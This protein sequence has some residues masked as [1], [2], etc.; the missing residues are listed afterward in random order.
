ML[1]LTPEFCKTAPSAQTMID[2]LKGTWVSSL[3]ADMNVVA[4][5]APHFEEDLRVDWVHSTLSGG[6]TGKSI[7]E[8]GPLEAYH[9]YK[10]EKFGALPAVSIESNNIAFL[11]CLIIKELFHLRSS[12]LYGDFIPY[13]SANTNR[14][15]ICWASGILY[16][17]VRPLE[18]L[19]HMQRTSDVIFLWTH[20][21][22]RTILEQ[23]SQAHSFFDPRRNVFIEQDGFICEHHYRSYV[24]EKGGVFSGG[25]D[26]FS[27]WLTKQDIMAFLAR[28]GFTEITVGLDHPQNPAGPA[29]YFLACRP[30]AKLQGAK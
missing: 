11:K 9:T 1:E 13:L 3:P 12:F 25:G 18:L 26:S 8:L 30:A 27:Y 7:I 4:G 29:M 24:H 5:T 20:Y 19:F 21:Y 6:L 10:F 15:D 23:N 14:F 28:Y 16:H 22:D 17:Q 2:I